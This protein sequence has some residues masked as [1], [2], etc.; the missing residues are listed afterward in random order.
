[1]TTGT[2]KTDELE[3]AV[4]ALTDDAAEQLTALKAEVLKVVEA[5]FDALSKVIQQR[6]LLAVGIGFGLG[7][8]LARLLYRKRS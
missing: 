3:S 4:S 5:R 6:P 8:A 2:K 1:M 7:Y